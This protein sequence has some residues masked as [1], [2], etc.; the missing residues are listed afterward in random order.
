MQ[1]GLALTENMPLPAEAPFI[2]QAVKAGYSSL[3]TNEG[4]V[5]DAFL[6]CA[7]RW[8]TAQD[9]LPGNR[10]RRSIGTGVSVVPV[11]LRTPTAIAMSALTAADLTEGTFI[12]GVGSGSP[13]G[14]ATAYGTPVYPVIPLMRDYLTVLRRLLDGETVTYEGSVLKIRGVRLG[15]EPKLPVP[16]H[17]AALGP[18]MLHLAGELADGVLLNWCTAEWVAWSRER[19]AEA[20]LRAG[21]DPS[22]V[23]IGEYIR[24]CIDDDV[25]AARRAFARQALNYSGALTP[26]SHYRL[27]FE[28]MGFKAVLDRVLALHQSGAPEEQVLGALPD[29]LLLRVGYFGAAAGALAALRRLSAGLD[30]AVVR[31][32]PSSTEPRSIHSVIDACRPPWE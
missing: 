23:L 13:A 22:K 32:V 26:G 5:R 17:L 29:E 28:R 2:Y 19:V 3:W 7:H 18:R 27:H 31:I 15:A 11:L 14:H 6:T 25:A 21:R 9:A 20:A 16:L 8:Q 10:D 1:I 4:S 30:I 24:V 12:L